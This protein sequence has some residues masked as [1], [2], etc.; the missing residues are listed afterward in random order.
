MVQGA[1][2][3]VVVALSIYQVLHQ[4]LLPVQTKT[5][6]RAVAPHTILALVVVT[7]EVTLAVALLAIPITIICVY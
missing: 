2:R 1:I 3:L 7:V 6:Q 5:V 4:L